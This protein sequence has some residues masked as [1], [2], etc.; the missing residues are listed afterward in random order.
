MST[1]PK[2]IKDLLQRRQVVTSLVVFGLITSILWLL[3]LTF[4]NYLDHS[5]IAELGRSIDTQA[6][7]T[8]SI[9][10]L[11]HSIQNQ[12][13]SSGIRAI[14][15]FS[16][17]GNTVIASAGNLSKD[18][19][20]KW[21]LAD[22]NV[23]DKVRKSL[24]KGVFGIRFRSPGRD[25]YAIL[26]LSPPQKIKTHL[27]RRGNDWRNPAWHSKA[28]VASMSPKVLLNRIKSQFQ[29]ENT[30]SFK[31]NKD[32]YVGAIL[33]ESNS[34]WL[35]TLAW[36]SL[37]FL[38]ILFGLGIFAVLATMS[39]T[40]KKVILQPIT[41]YTC[42]IKERR[43]GNRDVR[44]R[45]NG[46]AEF[47]ELAEQWNSLLDFKEVAQDQNLVLST[48]LE[49]VPV[50]IEV[51]DPSYQIEY[52]N[53]AYLSMT[54]YSL[55]E[56]IGQTPSQLLQM[57]D[58]EG[59]L[60]G[61][62][63]VAITKGK[64]WSGDLTIRHKTGRKLIC[65]TTLVPIFDQNDTL[66][67]IVTVR[68]DITDIKNDANELLIAKQA[69]ESADKAKSEFLTNMSHELRT[70]LNS[71]IGFSELLASEKLGPL[72]ND[73]YRE[74]AALIETSSHSLL[75]SINSVLELS[76][77]DTGKVNP[78]KDQFDV[79]ATLKKIVRTKRKRIEKLDVEIVDELHGQTMVVCDRDLFGKSI[80][81][82]VCNAIK[83]NKDGGT[84]TI[85]CNTTS[86]KA[87][88]FISDTGTGIAEDHIAHIT[89]PFYRIDNSFRRKQD[90]V[91]LGLT[92]V[93][94][95]CDV[96]DIP[97]EITSQPGVGTT[98]TLTL[99]RPAQHL[100]SLPDHERVAL[101][102]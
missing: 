69:A 7:L 94:K 14:A 93:K 70:P 43:I 50:G 9:N 87:E 44:A 42:V 6:R 78:V 8:K 15:L 81:F 3:L 22:K 58:F 89:K 74:F 91:G 29:P 60:N 33:I 75:S 61:D 11:Q 95:F 39:T 98:V 53:P 72:G 54:G 67:R 36:R 66:K 62:S 51:T 96:Q 20:A 24:D 41:D 1:A 38:C 84:V 21:I 17:D 28:E 86:D 82:L 23:R 92:L 4:A 25:W 13:N 100:K 80:N 10:F 99:P 52:A 16:K 40:I 47:D 57:K 63:L 73:V 101:A 46:I 48:L 64:T 76:R 71:I 18:Q 45:S 83:Y 19:K 35:A 97:F 32:E 31:V 30:Y 59:P 5:R 34:Q 102:G 65:N 90:G 56:I 37:A 26:P 77:L 68:H 88:I 49:H 79:V 85:G 12:V 27:F 2:S 55:A